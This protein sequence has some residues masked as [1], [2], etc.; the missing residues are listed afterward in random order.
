ME[1]KEK[2]NIT[3]DSNQSHSVPSENGKE[4][5]SDF[6]TNLMF[7]KRQSRPKPEIEHS[8]QQ[9]EVDY[10]TLM[11]QIDDVV[12]SLKELKPLLKQFSPII[13]YIKKKIE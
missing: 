12:T 4:S 13:N 11:D 7:G 9:N 5:Q 6:F 2:R 8:S 1:E 10:L 3:E